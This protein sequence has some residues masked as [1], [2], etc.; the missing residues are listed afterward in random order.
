MGSVRSL[1]LYSG[2]IAGRLVVQWWCVICLRTLQCRK[3]IGVTTMKHCSSARRIA[4]CA[5]TCNDVE[6]TSFQPQTFAHHHSS[7]YRSLTTDIRRFCVVTLML[8][9][10]RWCGYVCMCIDCNISQ[11]VHRTQYQMLCS[12]DVI[13]VIYRHCRNRSSCV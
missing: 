5:C 7:F 2:R 1:D 11:C 12:Y 9:G 6:V 3:H 13:L 10:F 4:T 8:S